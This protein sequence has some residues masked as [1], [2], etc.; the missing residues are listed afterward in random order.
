[1]DKT[2]MEK[3]IEKSQHHFLTDNNEELNYM[4]RHLITYLYDT[5]SQH[6]DRLNHFIHRIKGT[7]GTIGLSDIAEVSENL[8]ALL[9]AQLEQSNQELKI[10][11]SAG[12]LIHLF[13]KHLN[14]RILKSTDESETQNREKLQDQKLGTIL[15]VDDD[16]NL[17]NF[18]ERVLV[19]EGFNVFITNNSE[20]AI[21]L[22]K[23]KSVDLAIFDI[24]MPGRSGFDMYEEIAELD[25]G[26]PFIFL[27]GLNSK[28]IKNKALRTGAETFLPKPVD[29]EELVSLIIGTLNKKQKIE[30]QFYKDELTGAELRKGFVKAFEKEKEAFIE[31][32]RLCSVAFLDL[33][34]FKSIN[35]TH[36]H[37]FGDTILV[38]FVNMIKKHL[39]NQAQIYR[40]GGDEFLILFPNHSELEAK[41]IIESIRQETQSTPFVVPNENSTIHLSFSAGIAQLKQGQSSQNILLEKA[42]KALYTAKKNGKNQTVLDSDIKTSSTKK[43]LVVDDE[44]LLANI[45]KTRLNYLGYV[46]D[47]ARDGQEALSKISEKTYDLMLLDIMLPKMTGIEVL[48]KIEKFCQK[49]NLKIIMLSGKRSESTMIESLKLGADDYL[50]KP[51]SLDLLEHKIKKI[52]VNKALDES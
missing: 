46:V 49:D 2:K 52:L 44:L 37:L 32:E 47:Y 43:I 27:S 9:H 38:N 20:E 34:Y 45:I 5:D 41:H 33:D 18:L 24:V 17:L 30:N 13:E 6:F 8:E 26:I 35:D 14:Q 31:K 36:G 22:L 15:I 10:I 12:Q 42:D 23:T 16:V 28:E 29:P 4:T 25:N 51:F 48:K 1:M 7:A 39:S 11:K 3:M 21:D 50:E 40:F 19:T